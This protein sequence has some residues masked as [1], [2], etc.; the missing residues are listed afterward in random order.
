MRHLVTRR[1]VTALDNIPEADLIEVA[2][3][4]GWQVVVRKNDFVPGQ[5][6]LYCEID[7]FIPETDSRFAFLMNSGVRT[8]VDGRRGHVLRTRKLRGQV[9]QGLIL[10]LEDFP[11]IV[12]A[13]ADVDLADL[14]GFELW[15]PPLPSGS[16][17]IIGPFPSFL[18]KTDESRWQNLTPEEL[19]AALAYEEIFVTEKLDGSSC[20]VFVDNDHNLHVCGRNWELS[21]DSD[22]FK[23]VSA[24]PVGQW[25][26]EYGVPGWYIQGEVYGEGVQGNPLAVK[27]RHFKVFTFRNVN[28]RLTPDAWPPVLKE[29]SVPILGLVLDTPVEVVDILPLVDGL[30]SA[31]NPDR[32]AE[33]V[34]VRGY[35]HGIE[36]ASFKVNSNSYLLKQK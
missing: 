21:Q 27:G 15:E 8:T 33:G 13:D 34:V 3:V 17:E 16:N 28:Y 20:S 1:C 5:E 36:K 24:S 35:Q 6:V 19:R 12:E 18:D 30:K 25:F 32:L 11:E 2:T 4:D 7:S 23:I 31:I 10:S 22:F 29:A 26:I 9:S 14:L